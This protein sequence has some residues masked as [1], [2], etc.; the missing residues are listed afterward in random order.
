[1]TNSEDL[2]RIIKESG[3]K[4]G[5]IAET[6]GITRYSLNQKIN[7]KFQFKA[8]EIQALCELLEINDL[9]EKERLFFA[10]DV[11]DSSTK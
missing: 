11:E 6:L 10:S 8:H 9:E 7:N 2:N 5:F 4:R 1:M 3:L